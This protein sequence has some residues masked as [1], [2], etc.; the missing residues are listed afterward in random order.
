MSQQKKQHYVPVFYLKNF[1]SDGKRINLW[2]I[3]LEK[4]RLS[5]LKGQC[6]KNFFYGRDRVFEQILGDIEA[7]A[8]TV[9]RGVVKDRKLP[10]QWH[11]N[12]KDLMLYIL[13]QH[14][15]TQNSSEALIDSIKQKKNILKECE[16][17]CEVHVPESLVKEIDREYEMTEQVAPQMGILSAFKN[18]DS[19]AELAIKLLINKTQTEFVTSDHP[20]V[21]YNQLLNYDREIQ[22]KVAYPTTGLFAKGIQLFFPISPTEALLVYDDDVYSTGNSDK[23]NIPIYHKQDVTAVNMLQMC[24]GSQNIYFKDGA[25]DVES[26]HNISE[27]YMKKSLT[28]LY[29]TPAPKLED[30]TDVEE[31]KSSFSVVSFRGIH[32]DLNL[33]FIR[34]KPNA[35]E[36]QAEVKR[37]IEKGTV[38]AGIFWRKLP[39]GGTGKLSPFANK[40]NL[41]EKNIIDL[42]KKVY[43][44]VNRRHI[45]EHWYQAIQA[46]LKIP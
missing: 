26:L 3:S 8:S 6:Q 39:A 29:S 36:F 10:P 35:K 15:R 33:P 13:I 30:F 20:V 28:D 31:T 23:T 27:P 43:I 16:A 25:F 24:S 11:K 7:G 12:Y 45:G 4:K 44:E 34:L 22:Q 42:M 38:P 1:S 37:S 9:L 2:N 14:F 21:L 40:I 19:V 5:G 18:F 41:M 17:L 32:T 46:F